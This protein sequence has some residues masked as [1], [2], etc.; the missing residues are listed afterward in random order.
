MC[1]SLFLFSLRGFLAKM[2]FLHSSSYG[3]EVPI[4]DKKNS[5]SRQ[6][7]DTQSLTSF[8]DSSSLKPD[9]GAIEEWC[10]GSIVPGLL[11]SSTYAPLDL[12]GA[13]CSEEQDMDASSVQSGSASDAS[14]AEHTSSEMSDLDG[15]GCSSLGSS[16]TSYSSI[17][18]V[19]ALLCV[20]SLEAEASVVKALQETSRLCWSEA[21]RHLF[22]GSSLDDNKGLTNDVEAGSKLQ[23]LEKTFSCH[24]YRFLYGFVYETQPDLHQ[25]VTDQ[26]LSQCVGC[27]MNY[28]RA[29]RQL[30]RSMSVVFD[31]SSITSLDAE[32]LR[33]DLQRITAAFRKGVSWLSSNQGRAL[34]HRNASSSPMIDLTSDDQP[35]EYDSSTAEKVLLCAIVE[36]FAESERFCSSE[37]P[38]GLED[39]QKTLDHCIQHLASLPFVTSSI[40]NS[41][42][43]YEQ[44]FFA[45]LIHTSVHSSRALRRLGEQCLRNV[46]EY[47]RNDEK[48]KYH[49]TGAWLRQALKT[50]CRRWKRILSRR[51]VLQT[52]NSVSKQLPA[53]CSDDAPSPSVQR[54]QLLIRIYRVVFAVKKFCCDTQSSTPFLFLLPLICSAVDALASLCEEGHEVVGNLLVPLFGWCQLAEIGFLLSK[55]LQRVLRCLLRCCG[56]Q[57]AQHSRIDALRV[58]HW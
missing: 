48:E 18:A 20:P 1:I 43:S 7:S 8:S 17:P 24:V 56:D 37:V 36:L 55:Q 22:C 23:K 11:P 42:A 25:Y 19:D 52:S 2:S 53:P 38:K 47:F 46:L 30:L 32:Y 9:E 5:G 3:Y 58:G 39:L 31:I 13:C 57:N 40:V 54:A 34:E 27:V 12:R 29:R 10:V 51:T 33:W 15:G 14:V 26:V 21:G 41:L 16:D 49:Q 4:V 45:S 35:S 44:R 6:E 28:H 50:S